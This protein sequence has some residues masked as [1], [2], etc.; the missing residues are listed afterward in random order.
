MNDF[1]NMHKKN[2]TLQRPGNFKTPNEV[3]YTLFF[4][5]AFEFVRKYLCYLFKIKYKLTTWIQ[6]L[7]Y[8][9]SMMGCYQNLPKTT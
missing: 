8:Y 1:L 4:F 5:N 3:C 6:E 2:L 7:K 9:F